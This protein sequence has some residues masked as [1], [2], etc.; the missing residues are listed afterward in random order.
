MELYI[1]PTF[2]RQSTK[3]KT[4]LHSRRDSPV[5][6]IYE[7][8]EYGEPEIRLIWLRYNL[9]GTSVVL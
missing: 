7:D 6:W 3:Q 8:T 1:L 2:T 4:N 9:L 5:S